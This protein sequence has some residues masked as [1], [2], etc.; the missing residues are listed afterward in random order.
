MNKSFPRLLLMGTPLLA[1]DVFEAIIKMGYPI[2][3]IVSQ[4]DSLIGRH[5]IL[6]PTPTKVLAQ[7]YGIPCF[8][9]EKIKLD[10]QFLSTL[11]IDYIITLAYGQIVP[12][13]VLD[14]PKFGAF[15]LHGSLLPALRGASPIRYSFIHGDSVTGMTLMNMV[16]AMDAGAMFAQASL[17]IA[18]DDVYTTLLG[19]FSSFTIDFVQKYLP[20]LFAGELIAKEQDERLVTFAPLIKKEHELLN[21]NLPKRAFIG[22]IKGL[23]DEPGGYVKDGEKKFKI[24]R[25]VVE[26]DLCTHPLGTVIDVRKDGIILQLID[27]QIRLFDV[28]IEGRNRLTAQAF[29]AGYRSY[30]GRIFK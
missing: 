23:A 29:Y 24:F 5:K 20:K 3:G 10:H 21:L 7:K 9:P 25:A 4:P 16:L 18:E 19:K 11:H 28:Q 26:N 2:V 13:V 22:W 8:Q 27:G 6:T 12:Q 17:P 15:N 30:I 14:A 1:A